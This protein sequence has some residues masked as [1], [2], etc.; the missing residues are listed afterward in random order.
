MVTTKEPRRFKL[1]IGYYSTNQR[2][3]ILNNVGIRADNASVT[4]KL[5]QKIGCFIDSVCT[6]FSKL[7]WEKYR[8]SHRSRSSELKGVMKK[9]E[10]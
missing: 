6:Y 2:E 7:F 1:E 3:C 4:I 10:V 8:V 5:L 9:L